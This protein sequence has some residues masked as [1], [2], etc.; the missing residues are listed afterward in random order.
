MGAESCRHEVTSWKLEDAPEY[1]GV[2]GGRTELAGAHVV[3]VVDS[4]GSMRKDDVAGYSTRTD[5]VYDCLARE[6]VEPQLANGASN[7]S[8][9]VIEMNDEAEVTLE[10]A[11][12]D[13]ALKRY[14]VGCRNN[15]AR[16]HGNYL[17]ALD[18][19]RRTADRG[20]WKPQYTW[21]RL[22]SFCRGAPAFAQVLR[23]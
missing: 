2:V 15:Y 5:A 18:K 7:M 11:P 21:K 14:L 1:E 22:D 16:S 9:S 10:R 23:L 13:G 17:P 3:F 8:V 12:V 6:F 4:S 19:V 20:A